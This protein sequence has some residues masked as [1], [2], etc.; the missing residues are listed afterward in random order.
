MCRSLTFV[1]EFI[2]IHLRFDLVLVVMMVAESWVINLVIVA[3]ASFGHS[4]TTFLG[5]ANILRLARRRVL[6]SSFP[7]FSNVFKCFVKVL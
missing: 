6:F 1:F 3:M 7:I 2:W 5:D 4:S